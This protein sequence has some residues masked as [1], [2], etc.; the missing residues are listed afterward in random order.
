[1]QRSVIENSARQRRTSP[2]DGIA[3]PPRIGAALERAGIEAAY[4]AHARARGR[5]VGHV[6]YDVAESGESVADV[7]R[8]TA[9][10]LQHAGLV[11][12]REERPGEAPRDDPW[13]FDGGL[14]VHPEVDD[15]ADHLDHGLALSVLP[16][17]AERH[18]RRSVPHEQGRVR[19]E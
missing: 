14:R 7:A 16:R 8:D 10:D 9:L 5:E 17:A 6:P 18:E 13:R 3:L 12:V 11:G 1:M 4:R 19:G 15:V 2:A